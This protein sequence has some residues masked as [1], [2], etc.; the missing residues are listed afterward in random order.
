MYEK[1]RKRKKMG[2]SRENKRKKLKE[3]IGEKK[4]DNCVLGLV[5]P[6]N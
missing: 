3:T 1:V 2:E 6:K 4:K 5:G